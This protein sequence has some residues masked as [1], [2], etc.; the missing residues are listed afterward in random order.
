VQKTA[1]FKLHK[2]D[3]LNVAKMN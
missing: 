1:L 3:M 2:V